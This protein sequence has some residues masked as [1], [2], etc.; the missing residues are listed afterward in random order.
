[1]IIKVCKIEIVA[2]TRS[3]R[4]YYRS[5][6]F[7]FKNFFDSLLFCVERLTSER[8][9]CLM[10]T[11]SALLRASACRIALDYENFVEFSFS[12]RTRREFTYK[13]SRIRAVFSSRD[14]LCV[15]R[16]VSRFCRAYGFFYHRVENRLV[17]LVSDKH[18]EFFDRRRFDRRFSLRVAELRLGL[19]LEF[20]VL[21]FYGNDS[22]HTFA[23]IFARKHDVFFLYEIVR[24]C[25][26]VKNFSYARL[27]AD[28]VSTAFGRGN[29]IDERENAFGVTVG[30]LN[31][32]FDKYSVFFRLC[33]NGKIVKFGFPFV[34]V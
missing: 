4:A 33:V 23:E 29:I 19:S 34:K 13:F 32:E 24:F 3:E 26:I 18:V 31:G 10:L 1:M 2:D 12:A 8:Q 14:F 28:F 27:K 5:Y 21:H 20:N 6:F 25:V 17:F 16:R 7:V 15:F 11:I 22:R 30:M 9:N